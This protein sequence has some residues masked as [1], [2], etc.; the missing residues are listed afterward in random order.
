MKWL[1]LLTWFTARDYPDQL[2]YQWHDTEAACEAAAAT[3][4]QRR[5][6]YQSFKYVCIPFQR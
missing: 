1:L 5:R 3:M 6:F 4:E 2:K